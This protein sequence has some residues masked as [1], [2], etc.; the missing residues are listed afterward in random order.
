MVGSSKLFLNKSSS[1]DI[2]NVNLATKDA[3][4]SPVKKFHSKLKEEKSVLGKE[5]ARLGKKSWMPR[6][7]ELKEAR[8]K[9]EKKN[10]LRPTTPRQT[11]R[12]SRAT[13]E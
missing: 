4:N 7:K 13:G 9:V 6:V 11:R 10:F 2:E 5:A 8:G 3:Q 1:E 12:S